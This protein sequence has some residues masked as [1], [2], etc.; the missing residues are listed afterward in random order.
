MGI[1]IMHFRAETIGGKVDMSINET[2][3]ASVTITFK[4]LPPEEKN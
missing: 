3:G 1:R 4:D 2:G